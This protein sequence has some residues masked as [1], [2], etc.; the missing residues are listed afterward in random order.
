MIAGNQAS[1][2]LRFQQAIGQA[3]QNAA[4]DLLALYGAADIARS[5]LARTRA[6]QAPIADHHDGPAAASAL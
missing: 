2:G 6:A 3:R 4:L 1:D 5:C